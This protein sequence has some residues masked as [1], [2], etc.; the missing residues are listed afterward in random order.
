MTLIL[1]KMIVALRVSCRFL[2]LMLTKFHTG[3]I[4]SRL[5]PNPEKISICAAIFV[6]FSIPKFGGFL[7]KTKISCIN[8]YLE[9]T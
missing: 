8:L 5:S 7:T 4:K 1:E 9:C 3:N 2:P 6:T